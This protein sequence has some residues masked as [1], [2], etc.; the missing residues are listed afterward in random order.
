M[1]RQTLVISLLSAAMALLPACSSSPSRHVEIKPTTPPRASTGSQWTYKPAIAAKLAQ[2]EQGVFPRPPSL[3][4]AVDFWR[5]T[6]GVWH[7]SE[8]AF[9]DDRYMGVIYEVMVLPGN[10]GEGLTNQQKAI[11]EQRKAFWKN[12]LSDL[13]RKLRA[14]A[15]LD[16]FDKQ[17]IAKIQS[18][19][20]LH[21][22]LPEA[23]QRLRS[24]RGIKERFKRGLEISGRYDA[25]FRS[26]FREYNLPEDFAYLPHVES[27]FQASAKSH[28]GAVGMWQ[29]TKGAAE[30]FMPGKN[31]PDRRHDPIASAHG[32]A[33]YLKY[34]YNKL[35][36]WPTAVTSYNHGIGGMSRAQN[37]VGRDF[38]QIVERYQSP[39]FGFASRNYYAQ[40]LAARDI[41]A[42]PLAYFREGVNFEGPMGSTHYLAS[43]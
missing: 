2:K 11:V 25:Q 13:D 27:S 33:R 7:R 30:T 24:Q 26:I 36:D 37:Q 16:E 22:I 6:Y 28:A 43:E 3:E 32:A 8:V 35:N 17:T 1:Q 10:V 21:E 18:Q 41:A 40:F 15:P 19:G 31:K 34:A 14:K 5:K 38:E 4:P 29:F 9:H 42:N 39:I 23:S 12:R 20:N